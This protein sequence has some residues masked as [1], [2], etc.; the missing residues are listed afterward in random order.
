V[1]AIVDGARGELIDADPAAAGVQGIALAQRPAFDMPVDCAAGTLWVVEPRPLFEGGS[2]FQ[3]VDLRALV[4]SDLEVQP[5][6]EAGGLEVAADGSYWSIEHTEFGP[7]PSSHLTWIGHP[8]FLS[9]NIFATEHV[10]DLMADRVTSRLFL[11][12][13]C[14]TLPSPCDGGLHAFDTTTGAAVTPTGVDV[15]FPP[16]DVAIAR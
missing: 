3:R 15:G 14:A 9:Y 6:A 12:D 10:D 5:G 13:N 11:P 8:E 4:A 16:I 1:L 7:G 2:R